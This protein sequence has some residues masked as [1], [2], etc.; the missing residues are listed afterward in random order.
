MHL[1]NG[2]CKLVTRSGVVL[3]SRNK[4]VFQG[5]ILKSI[6]KI[7]K[8]ERAAQLQRIGC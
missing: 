7:G 4:N 8:S 3:L 1:I 6:D 5:Y 2:V